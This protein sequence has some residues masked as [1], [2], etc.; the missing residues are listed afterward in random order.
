METE[1]RAP[2]TLRLA[3]TPQQQATLR[4][5]IQTAYRREFNAQ[6]PHFLP[7]LAGLYRA[8]GVLVA[9]CGLNLARH[10]HLYLEQYLAQ[11][12]ETLLK[13]QSVAAV[14]RDSIIEVRDWLG[15]AAR[16]D[17]VLH[18]GREAERRAF[19]RRL[20][21]RRGPLV[22]LVAWE[23]GEAPL[24]VERL[25]LERVVSVNTAAAGGNASLMT[26]G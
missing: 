8:D 12:V 7:I 5:F 11:P 9:A 22:A 16:Y 4:E 14:R 3:G 23:P 26:L 24:A 13:Q 25:L 15:D 19:A 21:E 20:A 1:I 2:Y 17:V 10:D 6:I 18:H